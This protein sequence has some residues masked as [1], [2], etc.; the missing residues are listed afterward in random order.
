MHLSADRPCVAATASAERP[1]AALTS[2]GHL[3]GQRAGVLCL[4]LKFSLCY[5][6]AEGPEHKQLSPPDLSLP[7]CKAEINA[8]FVLKQSFPRPS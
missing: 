7:I 1:R 3:L 8:F 5:S 2:A 4:G 6:F